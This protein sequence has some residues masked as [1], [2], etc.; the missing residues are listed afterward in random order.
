MFVA[1]DKQGY[2]YFCKMDLLAGI[3]CNSGGVQVSLE[4][5]CYISVKELY[6]DECD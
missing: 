4:D 2:S 3:V 6:P 5:S 1:D